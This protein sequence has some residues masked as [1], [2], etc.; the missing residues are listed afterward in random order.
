MTCADQAGRVICL[1]ASSIGRATSGK[2]WCSE[3]WNWHKM[4]NLDPVTRWSVMLFDASRRIGCWEGALCS[5][6]DMSWRIGRPQEA[7]G[8]L[9]DVGNKENKVNVGE[10]SVVAEMLYVLTDCSLECHN[11]HI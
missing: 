1:N 7:F 8:G 2:T 11:N 5:L 6:G 10:S 9:F 3:K 4:S